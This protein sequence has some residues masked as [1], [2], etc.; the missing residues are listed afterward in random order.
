MK[1]ILVTGSNGLLGQKLVD[2]L[3][4]DKLIRLIASS[5]G[6][7]RLPYN[8]NYIYEPLDLINKKEVVRILD[9]YRPDSVINTAAMTQVD[10]CEENQSECRKD[11]IETVK[12]LVEAANNFNSHLIHLSSDFIFDGLHGPYKETDKASPPSYYGI[13]KLEGEKIIIS[14]SK[15]WSIVRT[16]LVYGVNKYMSRNNIVKWIKESL[17]AGNSIKI[18]NDQFRMPTFVNDLAVG[19]YKIS[20]Q[21]SLGV[22]HIS[23]NELMSIL[24]LAY[25]VASFFKLD[26]SLIIPILSTELGE[27]AKR[28]VSTGFILDKAINE[29]DYHPHSFEE[30]LEEIKKFY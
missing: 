27:K 11:N 22:Y 19:C 18:V 8:S 10:F 14:K 13:T 9:K 4:Q 26:Q 6:E 2:L 16:I 25:R 3:S 24:E 1:S 17:E 5:R 28:P 7:N 30:G 12:I 23:G 29:L 20:K 15:K 21:Q